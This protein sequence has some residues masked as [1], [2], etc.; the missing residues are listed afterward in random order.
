MYAIDGATPVFSPPGD[1][2]C[3]IDARFSSDGD[4]SQGPNNNSPGRRP[5]SEDVGEE[6]CYRTVRR[7]ED[8]VVLVITTRRGLPPDNSLPGSVRTVL[9]TE[10][11]I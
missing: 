9:L 2:Y 10:R 1:G 3:P 7:R 6:P 4:S 11:L 5:V 8:V